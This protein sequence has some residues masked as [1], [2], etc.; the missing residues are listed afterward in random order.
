M[1]N[2]NPK[3]WQLWELKIKILQRNFNSN[4][5]NPTATNPNKK[6]KIIF[7]VV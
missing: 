6:R 7:Y 1:Q 3:F 4:T 5:T 2:I